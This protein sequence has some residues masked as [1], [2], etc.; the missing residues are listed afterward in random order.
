M[1]TVNNAKVAFRALD[2]AR[3]GAHCHMFLNGREFRLCVRRGEV[4]YLADGQF[5][6]HRQFVWPVSHDTEQKIHAIF[7][8]WL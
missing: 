1:K 4:G 8:V 3:R 7:G 2:S 6:S 5:E